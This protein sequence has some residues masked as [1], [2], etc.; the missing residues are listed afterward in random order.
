M[1][2]VVTYLYTDGVT[3]Q[4]HVTAT[5]SGDF[6]TGT[7]TSSYLT[8]PGHRDNFADASTT[9]TRT[10]MTCSTYKNHGDYVSSQ[11]GTPRDDAG[12]SMIGMPVG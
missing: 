9:L 6:A 3:Y 12:Q 2:F 4:W 5:T 7:S 8:Y 11:D 10:G 1:E